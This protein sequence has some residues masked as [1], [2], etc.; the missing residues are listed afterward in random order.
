MQLMRERLFVLQSLTQ[1]VLH[2]RDHHILKQDL[3]ELKEFVLYLR[4]TPQQ[5][6]VYL[7]RSVLN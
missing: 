4:L 2:R 6:S 5:A 7:E 3:P 1:H